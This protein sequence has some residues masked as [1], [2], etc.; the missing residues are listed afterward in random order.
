MTHNWSVE[1]IV[2]MEKMFPDPQDREHVIQMHNE[3]AA[4]REEKRRAR[5]IAYGLSTYWLAR[6]T[7]NYKQA[8]CT[9]GKWLRWTPSKTKGRMAVHCHLPAGGCGMFSWA[10]GEPLV[11][12]AA[13]AYME[14]TT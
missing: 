4:K 3:A 11:H 7:L 5:A 1:Q 10:D 8:Q 2:Y 14:W 12:G 13:M 6:C 9:C